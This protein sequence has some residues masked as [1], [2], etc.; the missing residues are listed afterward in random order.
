MIFKLFSFFA[1][2]F[3]A[4]SQLNA[5]PTSNNDQPELIR[6]DVSG[7]QSANDLTTRFNRRDD[8]FYIQF[9]DS[10][11]DSCTKP[12]YDFQ[13]V[14]YNVQGK[15]KIVIYKSSDT[16]V[17]GTYY[18]ASYSASGCFTSNKI[19]CQNLGVNGIS[20]TETIDI[21]N[22]A[23]YYKII[24]SG[25]FKKRDNLDGSETLPFEKR[26]DCGV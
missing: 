10:S 19:A 23:S 8:D 21:N 24:V 11:G 25:P 18:L 17:L 5:S 26:E 7:E 15:T 22:P 4:I 6:K 16:I 12:F 1:I 2:A 9:C 14:C 20:G 13:N 3:I